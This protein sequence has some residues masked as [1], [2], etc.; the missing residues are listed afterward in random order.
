[1]EVNIPITIIQE[2]PSVVTIVSNLTQPAVNAAGVSQD[3]AVT[4][5]E[6]GLLQAI[7]KLTLMDKE[8]G[9]GGDSDEEGEEIECHGGYIFEQNDT[10][11][12]VEQAVVPEKEGKVKGLLKITAT[13]TTEF[14]GEMGLDG[15]HNVHSINGN[16]NLTKPPTDF[17]VPPPRADEPL[18]ENVDNLRN[19]DRF[20]FQPKQNKSKKYAGRFLPTGARPVPLGPDG[21]RK[22]GNWHFHY[23]G[24]QTNDSKYRRGASTSNLPSSE[25]KGHLDVDIMKRLGCN[26]D[27]VKKV[28][29]LV[30]FNYFY[31]FVIRQNQVSE[32]TQE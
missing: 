25:M 5:D 4:L 30:F 10:D 12:S 2:S 17:V 16:I 6:E 29:A 21:T 20:Y 3:T 26:V 18:F 15:S 1:M 13:G 23:N 27:R 8:G 9:D 22:Q 28:D 32:T 7:V 11:S 31:H 24:Y 14:I 19:W